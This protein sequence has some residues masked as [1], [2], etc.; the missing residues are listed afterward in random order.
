VEHPVVGPVTDDEVPVAVDDVVVV[1]VV[2]VVVDEEL[3]D[4]DVVQLPS[5]LRE[6][7]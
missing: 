1:V 5:D 6:I 4:V 3:V 2:V 7:V